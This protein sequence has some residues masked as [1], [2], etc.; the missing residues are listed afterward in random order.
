MSTADHAKILADRQAAM[1]K[2]RKIERF[3]DF[4]GRWHEGA[5]TADSPV[6]EDRQLSDEMRYYNT[7]CKGAGATLWL[8]VVGVEFNLLGKLELLSYDAMPGP[9]AWLACGGVAL[10]ATA[11]TVLY[12]TLTMRRQMERHTFRISVPSVVA[13]TAE[14]SEVEL[15]SRNK[16]F[17]AGIYSWVVRDAHERELLENGKEVQSAPVSDMASAEFQLNLEAQHRAARPSEEQSLPCAV[18]KLDSAAGQGAAADEPVVKPIE[19]LQFDLLDKMR[20]E[21]TRPLSGIRAELK[22]PAIITVIER[23]RIERVAAALAPEP[24][25]TADLQMF[26]RW[27]S[28]TQ[29]LFMTEKALEESPI[30]WMSY[31]AWGEAPPERPPERPV[32]HVVISQHKWIGSQE[33]VEVTTT[34]PV[35]EQPV[36]TIEHRSSSD[37]SQED[38]KED[39]ADEQPDVVY[40]PGTVGDLFQVYDIQAP[41]GG[42][43][44]PE[45][46][47]VNKPVFEALAR[48]KVA[49]KELF[50]RMMH[51]KIKDPSAL[52]WSVKDPSVESP[53]RGEFESLFTYKMKQW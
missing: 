39:D 32:E 10:A 27:F 12:T 25:A 13:I 38:E 24:T 28:R 29:K 18:Y 50:Y 22:L 37:D 21:L 52:D 1:R 48:N 47:Y 26:L 53:E 20:Q 46:Y 15:S 49:N 7:I 44:K 43:Y 4:T 42:A 8:S 31:D 33:V 30:D 19:L 35:E 6:M 16:D 36:P 45:E 51:S 2:P 5:T 34:I 14:R 3:R 17:V 9:I 23:E 11:P 41:L 40:A